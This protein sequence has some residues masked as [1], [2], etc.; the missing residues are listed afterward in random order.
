M[1]VFKLKN[2][3]LYLLLCLVGMLWFLAGQWSIYVC[4]NIVGQT[5]IGVYNVIYGT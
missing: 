4:N 2:N 5:I 1:C 3:F